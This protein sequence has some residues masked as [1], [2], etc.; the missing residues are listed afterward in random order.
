MGNA[1]KNGAR[2]WRGERPRLEY[3]RS[4]G[5]ESLEGNLAVAETANYDDFADAK[6]LLS[7]LLKMLASAQELPD[8]LERRT[9]LKQ[10]G[11]FQ[12]RLGAILVTRGILPEPR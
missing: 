8:G 7:L 12:R 4:F 1:V 2:R 9:A 6:E 3:N 11:I 10:I 5:N